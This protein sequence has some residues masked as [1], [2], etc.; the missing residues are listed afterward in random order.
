MLP[1]GFALAA[2]G[3]DADKAWEQDPAEAQKLP[4]NRAESHLSAAR[5]VGRLFYN[6]LPFLFPDVAFQDNLILKRYAGPG[7][8]CRVTLIEC[9]MFAVLHAPSFA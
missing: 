8:C 2:S 5:F 9:Q 6:K 4:E 7:Q 3:R 1:N